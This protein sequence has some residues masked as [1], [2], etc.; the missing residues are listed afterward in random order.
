MEDK[1]PD[2]ARPATAADRSRP[3]QEHAGTAGDRVIRWGATLSVLLV[4]GIAAVISYGH[5]YELVTRYGETGVTARVLP[6]TVDGLV[7]TCSLVLLDSARRDRRPPWHA[8]GLL[9]TGMCA[10]AAA[11]VAHGLSHGIAGAIVAG[12]PALVAVGSFELLIRLLRDSGPRTRSRQTSTPIEIAP[13]EPIAP[14][15]TSQ[16]ELLPQTDPVLL[17]AREHYASHIAGGQLP[18][19]R[20]IKRDLHVGHAKATRVRAALADPSEPEAQAE[21][22]AEAA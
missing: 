1:S 3:G 19:V 15:E 9:A 6:L 7:G 14:V 18:S 5:A 17:T 4:T 8:W 12:W 22:E 13:P 20:A 16:Q 11:N 2:P 21:A 10:T